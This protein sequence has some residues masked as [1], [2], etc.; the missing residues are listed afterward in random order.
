MQ[1]RGRGAS[2]GGFYNF[3]R[4]F[5]IIRTNS[6]SLS[7]NLNARKR[8]KEEKERTYEGAETLRRRDGHSILWHVSNL[9]VHVATGCEQAWMTLQILISAK[10]AFPIGD[11]VM[12]Y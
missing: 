8:E 7:V 2:R 4:P 6:R 11:R 3:S 1:I 10:I 9:I 12:R 5:R